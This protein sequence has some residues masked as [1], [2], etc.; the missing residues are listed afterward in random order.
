MISRVREFNLKWTSSQE[1]GKI[2]VAWYIS[3]FFVIHYLQIYL[4]I[5][6]EFSGYLKPTISYITFDPQFPHWSRWLL[7]SHT[8]FWPTCL[9]CSR[10]FLRAAKWWKSSQNREPQVFRMRE[11]FVDFDLK[12]EEREVALVA[13]PPAWGRFRWAECWGGWFYPYHCSQPASDSHQAELFFPVSDDIVQVDQ[14]RQKD[15]QRT[16]LGADRWG[17]EGLSHLMD[18]TVLTLISEIRTSHPFWP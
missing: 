5:K 7:L 14:R 12:V 16:P 17:G 1:V 11:P 13:A 10:V 15:R 18:Y 9:K 3:K 4:G 2:K 6:I 8:S